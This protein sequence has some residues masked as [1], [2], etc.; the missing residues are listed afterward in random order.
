MSGRNGLKLGAKK[1]LRNYPWKKPELDPTF[2]APLLRAL[3]RGLPS[4]SKRVPT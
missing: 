2:E 1:A 4:A 3:F